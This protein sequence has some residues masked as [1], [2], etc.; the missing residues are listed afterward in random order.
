MPTKKVKPPIETVS[1]LIEKQAKLINNMLNM[2]LEEFLNELP[3]TTKGFLDS[4]TI[5]LINIIEENPK[6][7]DIRYIRLKLKQR[8]RYVFNEIQKFYV[9]KGLL[10]YEGTIYYQDTTLQKPLDWKSKLNFF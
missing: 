5:N 9:Q 3:E 1:L 8:L 2:P 4:R 10:Q 6:L 7:W